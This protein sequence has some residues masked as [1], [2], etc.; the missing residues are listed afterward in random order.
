MFNKREENRGFTLI[1][2]LVVIAIIAILAAIL[3]PVFAK[4]R[5][6][7]RQT[8]CASNLKQIVTAWQMYAQDYDETACPAYYYV[9]GNWSDE[10]AWDFHIVD[11]VAG[12]GFLAP[13]TKSGA[14]NKC[15]SF[16]VSSDATSN[17]EF[18]GYAYNASYIGGDPYNDGVTYP[19]TPASLAKIQNP[20]ETI[21][22]AESA[23]WSSY[24]GTGKF[25]GNNYLRA[26]KDLFFV[27]WD[28]G[29]V[30]FRHNGMANVAY[31]DG[32]VKA[33]SSKYHYDAE[34]QLGAL[35]EYDDAYDLN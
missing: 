4:A 34:H 35:S 19:T 18:T 8:A 11:G 22:F 10:Y 6:K 1:E 3:F 28:T 29:K 33:V 21:L 15:P 5:E 23:I 17:R 31:A 7:A 12:E 20:S 30:H 14:I 13:Y 26:P 9:G 25:W 2:L 16:V 32:H 27:S 24:G